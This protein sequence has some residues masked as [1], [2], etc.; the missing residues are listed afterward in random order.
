MNTFQ[1]LMSK[2]RF[3]GNIGKQTKQMIQLFI[4]FANQIFV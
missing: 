4:V 2:P 1:I 3:G